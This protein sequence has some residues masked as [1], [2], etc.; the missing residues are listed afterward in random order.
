MLQSVR[1][2]TAHLAGKFNF[3]A[4]HVS[5]LNA[6]PPASS[7]NPGACRRRCDLQRN[8]AIAYPDGSYGRELKG[9]ATAKNWSKGGFVVRHSSSIRLTAQNKEIGQ[10]RRRLSLSTVLQSLEPPMLL[11]SSYPVLIA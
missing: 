3:L 2:Y 1:H 11:S 5:N 10:M 6:N 9:F 4:I 7:P 8:T